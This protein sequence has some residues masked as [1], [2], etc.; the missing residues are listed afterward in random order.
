[1]IGRDFVKR[2]LVMLTIMIFLVG[3]SASNEYLDDAMSLRR[4]ILNGNGCTFEADITADYGDKI[5]SF[6]VACAVDA[7]GNINFT[8][9]YPQSIAGITGNLSAEGGKLTFD[10][11]VLAFE[12][13]AD[14]Q[15]TPI[16]GPWMF[17]NAIRSGY[18]KA[19]GKDNEN[20]RIQIDDS[21]HED[22][23]H[24]DVWTDKNNVPV[25]AEIVWKDRRIVSLDVENFV[26]L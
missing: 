13:L 9:T 18:L 8:V 21:Y 22:A 14:G 23:A 1:M 25:R 2:L 24:V 17:V 3:C 19:A 11:Q 15:I 4:Q 26:I 12:M 7:I 20:V 6:S 10:D 5:Y 16:S